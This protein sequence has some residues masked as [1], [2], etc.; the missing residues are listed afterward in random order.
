MVVEGQVCLFV[1]SSELGVLQG[2]PSFLHSLSTS[3]G[4]AL[5]C[6]TVFVPISARCFSPGV[7]LLPAPKSC[8]Y[9]EPASPAGQGTPCQCLPPATDHG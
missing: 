7:T 4:E 2:C 8:L 3:V 5:W 9:P 6:C 1:L